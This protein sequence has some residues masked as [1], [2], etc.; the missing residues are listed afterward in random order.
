MLLGVTASVLGG[1]ARYPVIEK[2]V[3]CQI[4]ID[5]DNVGRT[6][7]IGNRAKSVGKSR[8]AQPVVKWMTRND[9]AG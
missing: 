7:V 6:G 4:M 1:I 2:P 8:A 3:A 9:A 5:A